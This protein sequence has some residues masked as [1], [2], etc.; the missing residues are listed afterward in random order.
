[1][2]RM[3]IWRLRAA[4]RPF[5]LTSEKLAAVAEESARFGT[6]EAVIEAVSKVSPVIPAVSGLPLFDRR[7][8]ARAT[9]AVSI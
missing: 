2:T 7:Q 5:M 8:L 3:A 9:N 1:M 6:L 4:W